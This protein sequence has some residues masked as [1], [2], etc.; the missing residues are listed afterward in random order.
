MFVIGGQET[1]NY[2]T[3]GNQSN[4]NYGGGFEWSPGPRTRVSGLKEKRFFG[5]GHEFALQH[6]T[7]RTAWRLSS[8]KDA[9][10]LPAELTTASL[11]TAFD[12]LF[13]A[14]ASQFP[15]PILR[16][17]EVERRLEQGGIPPDLIL[18]RSFLTARVF[19]Q[20][21]RQAAVTIL[22]AR[23]NITFAVNLTEREALST[24]VG[25]VDD[26]S[27]SSVIE[28]RS[29]SANWSH[30]LSPLSSVS[31]LASQIHTTGTSAA[32]LESTQYLAR[33]LFSH[34]LGRRT[35]ATLGARMRRF[36]SSVVGSDFQEKAL[37]GSLS[38]IF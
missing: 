31:L 36:E 22:G 14:L 21:S 32:G 10:A 34:R 23:N 7:P 24:A 2:T 13:D 1:N 3:A 37:T 35:T 9:T 16:A 4:A 38:M 27:L 28:Q 19:V 29:I 33:L 20:Q 6:R 30:R 11:G 25:P 17:E 26:F 5:D 15:D 12:L 8:R 18:A